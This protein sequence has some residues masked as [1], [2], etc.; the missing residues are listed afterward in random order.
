MK[1]QRI[2][3]G[4]LVL[5]SIVIVVIAVHGTTPEEKDISAVLFLLPLGIY[6]ICTKERLLYYP[7]EE[8]EGYHNSM[9]P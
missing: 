2:V 9:G 1:V 4:L 7:E 6:T 5:L 3:G 8:A